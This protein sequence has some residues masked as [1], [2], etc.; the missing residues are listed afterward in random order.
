MKNIFLITG[1]PGTGKTT[2]IRKI[3]AQ[4][5]IIASGF[6]TEEIREGGKRLGF[7]IITLD[8]QQGI[9]AHV[10]KPGTPRISRYGVDLAELEA[11]GVDAVRRA[12]TD[13]EIVVI[14][15]IGPMEI[16]STQFRSVVME[17]LEGDVPVLGSIV[18]RSMEFTDRIKA[19]PNV[20]LI[21]IRRDN[22]E[23]VVDRGLR[24]MNE[25]CQKF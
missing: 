25:I 22:R 5:P 18:G 15:E 24:W 6:Y 7:K 2:A 3:V 1:A 9:L 11:L 14:D 13:G 16:L 12:I 4:G 21:E 20:Y 23:E 8:G 19:H 10:N 17:V